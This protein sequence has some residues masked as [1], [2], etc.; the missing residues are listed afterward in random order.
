MSRFILQQSI[1][2]QIKYKSYRRCKNVYLSCQR[3][4]LRTLPTQGFRCSLCEHNIGDRVPCSATVF[5]GHSWTQKPASMYEKTCGRP[6]KQ[7]INPVSL[8]NTGSYHLRSIDHD[9]CRGGF[10]KN[11]CQKPT[12]SKTRPGY[13][14]C[15]NYGEI[16]GHHISP[17][18]NCQ[19]NARNQTNKSKRRSW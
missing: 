10:T 13:V 5:R 9:S 6:L 4:I 7:L 15:A 11:I 18:E 2:P 19:C 16:T 1:P 3:R 14:L 12:I 17:G 8:V